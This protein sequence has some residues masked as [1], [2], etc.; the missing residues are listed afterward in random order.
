MQGCGIRPDIPCASLKYTAALINP[1]DVILL[2]GS[3]N[4]VTYQVCSR[5]SDVID[6]AQLPSRIE[7]INGTPR[8]GCHSIDE[9]PYA[10]I[11][12]HGQKSRHKESA[13]VDI[14][15]VVLENVE[16]ELND[17]TLS[18]SNTVMNNASLSTL[19]VDKNFPCKDLK[20][21]IENSTFEKRRKCGDL[22]GCEVLGDHRLAC[23]HALVTVSRSTFLDSKFMVFT[24][25]YGEVIV[26]QSE[27]SKVRSYET[28]IGG[29]NVT[30]VNG[31]GILK[32]KRSTF[33]G[34]VHI[35]PIL[36][37]INL[38]ESALR[39]ETWAGSINTT[40]A[41]VKIFDSIFIGN[42]RAVSISRPFRNVL[43]SHCRFE[44]NHAMHAAAALRLALDYGIRVVITHSIFL[45]NSAGTTTHLNVENRFTIEQQQVHL[46]SEQYKGVIDLVGK[47]GNKPCSFLS[48][49]QDI[50]I[51]CIVSSL[52]PFKILRIRSFLVVKITVA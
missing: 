21:H 42:E 14:R 10:M 31:S 29:V 50:S 11:R 41:T 23:Q 28:G 52:F 36:S 12:L 26:D 45:G 47:G 35:E 8:I 18:I 17:L 16:V 37:A 40:N 4:G 20:V 33:R 39:V 7:G 30:F 38:E 32:V 49:K 24:V 15:N 34:Q 22:V 6:F 13:R 51:I 48:I 3:I 2:D 46:N 9:E 44:S 25:G 19:C 1:L 43:I 5:E 27:F